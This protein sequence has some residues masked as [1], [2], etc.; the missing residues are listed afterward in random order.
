MLLKAYTSSDVPAIRTALHD[1]LQH[2]L[3][4]SILFQDQPDELHL[5]LASLPTSRR[6]PGAESLDGARLTDEAESVIVFLDDCLQRCLKTPYRYIEELY[7]MGSTIDPHNQSPDQ[8]PSPLLMTVLEQL[9]IKVEK[10]YLSPSDTLALATFVRKLVVRLIGK[11]HTWKV[12]LPIAGNIDAVLNSDRL[13]PDYPIITGAIRREV[14]LLWACLQPTLDPPAP[15]GPARRDIQIFLDEVE[16]ILVRAS[17]PSC[18][19]S[20]WR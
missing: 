17:S 11:L 18:Y 4:E 2:V 16:Q 12:L 8:Y 13:F 7:G 19:L 15:S 14:G 9:S 5:W 10:K 6:E 3:V 20:E 1:L